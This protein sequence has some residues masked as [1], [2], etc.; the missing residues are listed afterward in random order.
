[1]ASRRSD[2]WQEIATDSSDAHERY[3]LGETQKA[4]S[5]T[6][7]HSVHCEDML[8]SLVEQERE[9]ILSVQVILFL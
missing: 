2:R 6:V 9:S 7:N 5:K 8:S 3:D 4:A 1:L